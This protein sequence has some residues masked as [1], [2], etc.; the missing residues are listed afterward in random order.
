MATIGGVCRDRERAG[1]GA[2][3]IGRVSVEHLV[4]IATADFY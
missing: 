3:E 2:G 4:K 1:R